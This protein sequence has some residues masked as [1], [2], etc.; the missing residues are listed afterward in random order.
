MSNK[1]NLLLV[2]LIAI[3]T[4]NLAWEHQTILIQMVHLKAYYHLAAQ[5]PF[6]YRILPALVY[7]ALAPGHRD[8]LTGMNE[9]FDSTASIFQ[10]VMDAACLSATLFFMWKIV[11]ALN[12]AAGPGGSFAFA[13]L[14]WLIIVIFGYY[15][16]P[17]RALFYPYDFPDLFF[18]AAIFFLCIR[19]EG[20]QEYLLAVAVFIA[21]LNKETAIFYVGLY[22]ALRAANPSANWTRVTTVIMSCAC[23]FVAARSL[24]M[25]LVRVLGA[26]LPT[27]NMQYE[28][29][30]AY[31]V[32]QL[33]NPL[34][35]FAM[36]NVCSYLYV[37]VYLVRK[38][39]ERVDYLILMMVIG[40][41][42]IMSVVGIVRELRIFV[43]ASLMLFV[44]LARHLDTLRGLLTIG[45]APAEHRSAL[46]SAAI[47]KVSYEDK[48][49]PGLRT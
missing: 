39:L 33:K 6:V 3:V 25:W 32:E 11:R 13:A 45:V 21:T 44:I 16:V 10:L 35:V 37:G 30:L 34:F 47:T 7:Y 9:P 31:T 28:F 1:N 24:V 23:A 17:N 26:G 36:L 5:E 18:A 12:P 43:P 38:R 29:H 8:I 46:R 22:V 20:R 49:I 14:C 42:G 15:M 40:W 4:L 19:L 48:T 2:F 41:A 27:H